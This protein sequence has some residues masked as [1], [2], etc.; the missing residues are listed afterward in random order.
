[1]WS[2]GCLAGTLVTNQLLFDRDRSHDTERPQSGDGISEP[3]AFDLTFLDTSSEWQ[4]T[5]RQCKS[6]IKACVSV[7]V[8]QRLTVAQALRHP[9]IAHPGFAQAMQAEYARAVADWSPRSNVS[10]ATDIVEY[11]KDPSPNVKALVP[12]YGARLHEEVRSH[13]FPSQMPIFPSQFKPLSFAAYTERHSH[14]PLSPIDE[15]APKPQ[16]VLKGNLDLAN[17]RL[18]GSAFQSTASKKRPADDGIS[19]LSIQDFAPPQTYQAS[20][21]AQDPPEEQ[22]SWNIRL[23]ESMYPEEPSGKGHNPFLHKRPRM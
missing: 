18:S 15:M 3:N 1:M 8:S 13:H 10:K 17:Q 9:W 21:I 2:V 22:S 19:N 14:T 12:A 4:A 5:S 11:A 16:K 6:F 7:D 23:A 20:Q